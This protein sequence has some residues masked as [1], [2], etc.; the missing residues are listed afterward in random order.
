MSINPEH[1]HPATPRTAYRQA[2]EALI[3]H[4][5]EWNRLVFSEASEAE[6][7]EWAV[8]STMLLSDHEDALET[9]IDARAKALVNAK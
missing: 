2:F 8:R 1:G 9:Y 4:Y 3:K 5:L 7:A 6:K